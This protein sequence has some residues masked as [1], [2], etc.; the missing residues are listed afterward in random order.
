MA[1]HLTSSA[2]ILAAALLIAA[3]GG[4]SGG[5]SASTS[6]SAGSS[7]SANS[8]ST[9]ASKPD[10]SGG[11]NTAGST[12]TAARPVSAPQVVSALHGGFRTV[13][14]ADYTNGFTAGI[15]IESGVE[16]MAIGHVVDGSSTSMTVYRAPAGASDLTAIVSRAMHRLVARPAFLPKLQRLS[17]LQ[18]ARVDGASAMAV[19]YRLAG[20]KAT[21][22]RQIFVVR[23]DWAYEISDQAAP[24]RY[25]ASLHALGDV[26]HSWHWQ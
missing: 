23:G 9:A 1:R 3:C 19:D 6:S 2:A 18:T 24:A 5:G 11:T 13:I 14:P 21:Y 12:G 26:L 20:R 22:R 15:H 7:T 25:A 10:V 17:S 16:Y 4:G 8:A